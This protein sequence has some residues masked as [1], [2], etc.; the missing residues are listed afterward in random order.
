MRH[1][2]TPGLSGWGQIR[3]YDVPRG[4]ADVDKTRTKLS[5]DLY[6][7]KNRSFVLDLT[8][9]LKTMK[10]LVSRSGN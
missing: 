10:T 9:A 3:D 6:Y 8:I 2:V 7:I 5:Y 1:L 4:T